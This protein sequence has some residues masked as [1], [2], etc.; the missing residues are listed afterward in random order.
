M[1]VY[2]K[3]CQLSL[4]SRWIGLEKSEM[5]IEYFCTPISV[6][7]IGW[8]NSIHY[9]FIRGY[10]DIVFAVN[11]ETCV[12]KYVYPLAKNFKDFLRLILACGSTTAVEQIIG[13]DKQQFEEF[14]QSDYNK[15]FPEQQ[16]VLDALKETLKLE[17]LNNPY[18]Y[19]KSI[20]NNFD[21]SKIQYSNE[22]Y[23]TLG[24]ERPDGTERKK[25]Y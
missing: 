18:E 12:D 8:E 25:I 7:V 20:Q 21:D 17:P 11:P 13:W 14:I 16:I 19:V 5:G 9:C 10:E 22:Y 15:I 4:D 6:E 24:L 2:K 23:D 1:T 3:Y